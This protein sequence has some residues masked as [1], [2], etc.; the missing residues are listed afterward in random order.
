MPTDLA[1]LRIAIDTKDF[2]KAGVELDRLESK[3]SRAERT[4]SKLPAVFTAIASSMA[5]REFIQYADT[6][7]L[8]EG[9]LSL[10][11]SSASELTKVQKEL[12][13]ISQ[14]SRVGFAD[15]ADLYARM[16]RSTEAL[17]YTS[18]ELL[19]VTETISKSF[20]ISGASAESANAA[21]IQLGQGF[22]SGTLRGEE[23]NSVMEQSPR[24][25]QAIADGMDVTIGQLRQLGADGKLTAETV[26][27]ALSSQ[28]DSIAKEFGKMPQTV[29]QSMT[30]MGNSIL[31]LVGDFDS[32]SGAT[33]DLSQGISDLAMFISENKGDIIEFGLDIGRSFEVAGTASA[34]AYLEASKLFYQIKDMFSL[35]DE[36]KA[37]ISIIDQQLKMLAEDMSITVDN[38]DEDTYALERN[39]EAVKANMEARTGVDTE[40]GGSGDA[41]MPSIGPMMGPDSEGYQAYLE[42]LEE[43]KSKMIASMY[44]VE[45]LVEQYEA[46][47]EV[48]SELRERSLITE[49]EEK[50]MRLSLEQKFQDDVTKITIK[51]MTAREKFAAKNSKDQV[52]TILGDMQKMTA[53]VANSNKTMFQIN[54]A[55][56]L[57]NAAVQLPASIMKTMEQYPYPISIAM[58]GLQ[59]AAGAA[60]IAAISSSSFGGGGGGSTTMPTSGGGFATAPGIAPS[61]IQGP[62]EEEEDTAKEVTIN[63]GDSAFVS[64]EM[65]REL[66][67]AI[68][69]EIGDGVVIRA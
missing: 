46:Q 9:R 2:K 18:Q 31:M 66:V 48:V 40:G 63:L 17:G 8:V 16:A 55:A 12:F 25:A 32:A 49:Q 23:L 7:K 42:Q 14:R 10:V 13:D 30:Q 11:T 50:A 52:T 27:N 64:T 22:A 33:D 61:D 59:A 20:V 21:I 56:A 53:G 43:Q 67:V 4:F 65:V 6:M 36:A 51:S 28:G 60:Q 47:Q 62:I 45:G 24:L 57:A 34:M 41:E 58:A 3:G 29:G 37:E 19:S 38:I 26:M 35:G 5:V 69:D 44:P 1:K 68:N 54:K 15:T 39:T